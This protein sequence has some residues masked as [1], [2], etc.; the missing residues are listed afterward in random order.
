MREEIH[1]IVVRCP[2]GL[3]DSKHICT[4]NIKRQRKFLSTY[5]SDCLKV[6][7]NTGE[8]LN[9]PISKTVSLII[10]MINGILRQRSL[11]LDKL[12]GMDR[13]V[14]DFCRRSLENPE[15]KLNG[16]YCNKIAINQ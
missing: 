4:R 8:F 3:N 14:A 6:G 12:Q 7:R 11:G 5:L 2:I 13:T 1:L 9:V 16:K 15:K 10:G